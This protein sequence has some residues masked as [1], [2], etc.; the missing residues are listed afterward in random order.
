[1]P[2]RRQIF[3]AMLL[4]SL[5]TMTAHAGEHRASRAN[6]VAE[7]PVQVVYQV[8]DGNE[9][10]LRALRNINN[11][12]D[13]DPSARI[14]VV[15]LGR[16]IDF[17]LDGAKDANDQPFD[18]T[19]AGLT[20]RKVEFRICANTLRSLNVRDDQVNPEAVVVPSGVAEIARLQVLQGYAYIRP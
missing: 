11:H 12:L 19:V 17:L 6:R 15:A 8:S 16:G 4:S 18:A 13:A 20:A 10:A 5:M 14:V 2:T 1:M 3:A 7:A 9:Q